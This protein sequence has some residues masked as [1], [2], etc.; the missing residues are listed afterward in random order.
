MSAETVTLSPPSPSLFY[1]MNLSSLDRPSF[2]L[3]LAH[4]YGDIVK[5]PSI[6]STYL[7]NHPSYLEY[8]LLKKP[9]NFVKAGLALKPLSATLGHGLLMLLGEK[10]QQRRRLLA[11]TFQPRHTEKFTALIAESTRKVIASWKNYSDPFDISH[12]MM[13]IVLTIAAQALFTRALNNDEIEKIIA[14]ISRENKYS[15]TFLPIM[16]W[17]PT[18]GNI[19]Y[20]QA[21]KYLKKFIKQMIAEHREHPAHYDDFLSVLLSATPSLSEQ[22]LFDEAKTFLLT[23]HE[24]TGTAL[25]WTWFLLGKHPEAYERMRQ[26]IDQVVGKNVVQQEDLSQLPYTKMVFEETLRLYP[27]IWITARKALIADTIG[28]YKIPAQS[29]ILICPYV[30]HR[31]PDFWPQPEEFIP[32]RFEAENSAMRPRYA[33]MPFG[34]GPRVCI[35]SNFALQI[36]LIILATISQHYQIK[37]I[38]DE[39]PELEHLISLK[40]KQG[41]WVT[42]RSTDDK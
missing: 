17:L 6:F 8:I 35:A 30:L 15:C 27:P 13:K 36:A 24:T 29:E 42:V 7:I 40:P 28:D 5:I 12:E 3:E 34:A 23:G 9:D 41:I 26:E 21:K 18:V 16:P 32:E 22:D 11:P 19:Y 31:H 39:E 38:P 10:W 14:A 25:S 4:D 37:L 2:F 1:R 20:H 33:Y